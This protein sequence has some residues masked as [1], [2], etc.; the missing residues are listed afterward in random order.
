MAT[1]KQKTAQAAF[2][3]KIAAAKVYHKKHGGKW[4]AAVKHAFKGR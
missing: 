4:S 2:K 3:K 1:A